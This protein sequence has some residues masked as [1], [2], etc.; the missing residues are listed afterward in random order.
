MSKH[1]NRKK[2]PED[3]FDEPDQSE[4]DADFNEP[5]TTKNSG[6]KKGVL[7][8]FGINFILFPLVVYLLSGAISS[9]SM[10]LALFPLGVNILIIFFLGSKDR[11]QVY[12]YLLGC[13]VTVLIAGTCIAL[14]RM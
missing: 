2:E 1:K 14:I 13:L 10:T 5:P 9:F 4:F 12:G 6:I 3:Q 11:Y 8:F 7:Y